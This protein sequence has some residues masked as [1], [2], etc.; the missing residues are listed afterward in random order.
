MSNK[1]FYGVC[2]IATT[3]EHFG[4][5]FRNPNRQRLGVTRDMFWWDGPTETAATPA[6]WAAEVINTL[7][8]MCTPIWATRAPTSWQMHERLEETLARALT[9]G[10]VAAK[11]R[12]LA[13]GDEFLAL[14]HPE[15]NEGIV[16]FR[17]EGD[18]ELVFTNL[19]DS[20]VLLVGG[21][22][23]RDDMVTIAG[24]LWQPAEIRMSPES[25]PISD[26][27]GT[28]AYLYPTAVYGVSDSGMLWPVPETDS[29]RRAT[30]D[31]LWGEP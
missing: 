22:W 29:D 13:P 25:G 23:D 6:E 3:E 20:E 19:S 2:H 18:Q 9:R 26:Y 7:A 10:G 11:R 4:P 15:G 30:A 17:T 28:D 5:N 1:P 8:P 27:K 24:S 31:E 14:D 12:K 16:G 21:A